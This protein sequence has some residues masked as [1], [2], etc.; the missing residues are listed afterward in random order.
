MLS[1]RIQKIGFSPTMQISG[2][3]KKMKAEGID[4]INLSVGEPDFPTPDNVKA[5]AH[6]AINQNM[7]KY[8]PNAGLPELKKAI[9]ERFLSDQQLEYTQEQIIV[10]SGAK[11]SLYNLCVV[12]L[13]PGDEAIIPAPYWVSYPSMVELADGVP[14]TI[15]TTEANEFRLTPA[16]LKAAITDKSKVLFLNNPCNPSGA[17]YNREQLEPIVKLALENQLTII[18]DEI[19]DKLV[20]DGQ[21]ATSVA[22]ISATARENSV[23]V[24]GVSKAYAMTGW[25]IGYAAGPR[26]IISEMDKIQSQSTSNACSVS[27]VATI[28][29]LRGPQ[30]SVQQML[31]EFQNRRD[32]MLSRLRQLDRVTCVKS[33]GAFYLFPNF[34]AYFNTT[35]NGKAIQNSYDLAFYLL[36]NAHV[37]V[38]PGAAFGSEGFIRFSYSN[39]TKNI[40][41]ALDRIEVALQKLKPMK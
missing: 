3:A 2:M 1:K 28:E 13:N 16:A 4:V 24:N 7:T 14:V 17:F 21:Q 9:C 26:E 38:V 6:D 8:T 37:A 20:Y 25:R 31:Q 5:A 35:F 36:K 10:S 12:L 33:R 19:Y 15:E 11:N 23:I 18:S 39:S 41:R 29:A 30:D 32:Y 40:E 34:S 27:Q 22:A